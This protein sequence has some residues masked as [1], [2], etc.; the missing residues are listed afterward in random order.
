MLPDY[1]SINIFKPKRRIKKPMIISFVAVVAVASIVIL[2]LYFIQKYVVTNQVKD[3]L[4]KISAS[5]DSSRNQLGIYPATINNM[6]ISSS[7]KVI[8]SGGGSFDGVSY[9]V[10][11]QST[12]DKSLVFHFDSIKRSEGILSGSCESGDDIPAPSVPGGLAIAYTSPTDIKATWN[13]SPYAAG[14]TLQCSIDDKFLEQ[15]SIKSTDTNAVCDNL[16]SA[17]VYY[18]RVKATNK[19]GDSYWTPVQQISTLYKQ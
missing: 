18:I 7:D 5:I 14:Y 11:G 13:T 8:I 9:C 1:Q 6:I 19:S 12:T 10:T 2:G 17:T 3:E 16:Q 15:K 4:N